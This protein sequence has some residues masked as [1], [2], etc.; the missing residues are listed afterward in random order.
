MTLTTLSY[1]INWLAY[2]AFHTSHRSLIY[3]NQVSGCFHRQQPCTSH[4]SGVTNRRSSDHGHSECSWEWGGSDAVARS[5]PCT[6]IRGLLRTGNRVAGAINE[7]D[8]AKF[9][10]S[11]IT[12]ILQNKI[13]VNVPKLILFK[14]VCDYWWALYHFHC[15]FIFHSKIVSSSEYGWTSLLQKF[16]QTFLHPIHETN[17]T[18]KLSIAKTM[19]FLK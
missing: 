7:L 1:T 9:Q 12:I 4:M 13:M 11:K 15:I 16:G 18:V 14:V 19:K 5:S 8:E 10:F 17:K 2:T 6:G 3:G